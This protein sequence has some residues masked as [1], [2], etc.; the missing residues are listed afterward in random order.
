MINKDCWILKWI[1]LEGFTNLPAS[2]KQFESL[3]D[4]RLKRAIREE[5]IQIDNNRSYTLT[6][7]GEEWIDNFDYDF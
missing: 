5:Y 7:N 3:I 1:S 2:K 6:K 4:N